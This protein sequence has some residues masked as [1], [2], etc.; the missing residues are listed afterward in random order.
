ML[1]IERG[2]DGV[3]HIVADGQLTTEDFDGFI[4]RFDT[5][6]G[7]GPTPMLVELGPR[8]SGWSLGGLWND[9]KFD[10]KHRRQFGRIAVLGDKA[11][12]K[13]MT[14]VSNPVFP[15]EMRFFQLS[16]RYEAE[17]WLRGGG[18]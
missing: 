4:P 14:E 17:Q 10:L 13:R 3:L 2:A 1:T 15:A 16:Q 11:W 7:E 8:F 5:L 6:A 18:R 12:Q 9:L